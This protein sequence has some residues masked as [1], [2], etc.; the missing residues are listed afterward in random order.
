MALSSRRPLSAK[1]HLRQSSIDLD[2]QL[3]R[4]EHAKECGNKLRSALKQLRNS[5]DEGEMITHK[6]IFKCFELEQTIL[7]N[8]K[9]AKS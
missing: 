8:L 7:R 1:Q 4:L 9:E 5:V 2:A 3:G 6:Q